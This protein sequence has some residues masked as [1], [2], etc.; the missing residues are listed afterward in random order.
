MK[1]TWF[2]CSALILIGNMAAAAPSGID[3]CKRDKY[4]SR[5]IK[6]IAPEAQAI[7]TNE[8]GELVGVFEYVAKDHNL[9]NLYLCGN[10]PGYY[11]VNN[12]SVS[13]WIGKVGETKTIELIY[14]DEYSVDAKATTHFI[15]NKYAKVEMTIH[16]KFTGEPEGA[17]YAP[18]T[19]TF[20]ADLPVAP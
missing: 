7:L 12:D 10:N 13:D 16:V 20:Y 11:Y 4:T 3:A 14:N 19:A 5:E 18:F 6:K 1:L 15:G 17:D 9:V 2:F 8:Y